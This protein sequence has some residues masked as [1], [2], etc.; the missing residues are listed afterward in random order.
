MNGNTGAN[1]RHRLTLAE[2]EAFDPHPIKNGSEW[3]YLCPFCADKERTFHLNC[4]SNL[5]NCK[6]ATCDVRGKLAD[7][8]ES[9][10]STRRQRAQAGLERA[11]GSSFKSESP[12]ELYSPLRISGKP[13]E[14]SASHS[15]QSPLDLTGLSSLRN[16]PAQ[17][18]LEGRG[19]HI[20]TIM[21]AGAFFSPSWSCFARPAVVFPVC[22]DK[23]VIWA[24]QGRFL[25]DFK[26]KA[27][28]DGRVGRG[29]YASPDAWDAPILFLTEAPLDAISL[30]YCGFPALAL[31]GVSE[32]P[33][34]WPLCLFK[35]VA[36]AFDADEGG[37]KAS[38]N[39][40]RDLAGF[41][42]S[43]LRVRPQGAKDWNEMLKQRGQSQL[44][45]Y[46]NS[47]LS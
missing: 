23:G 27:I 41:G 47:I 3:R 18:Y 31:C 46:V 15:K 44:N 12:L 45:R 11:F 30:W 9:S 1:S 16:T 19:F 25:G 26:P 17:A 13:R 32:R 40:R 42:A 21:A 10:P 20:E 38:A 7:E 6:R 22:D 8:N 29:V 24:A 4:D 35:R 37:E 43:C 14:I 34:L 33:W 5:W 2:L 36:L 39:W 28:T